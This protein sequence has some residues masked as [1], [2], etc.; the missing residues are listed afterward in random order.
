MKQTPQEII[1]L[2]RH[3]ETRLGEL[4]SERQQVLDHLHDLR[5]QLSLLET[6]PIPVSENSELSPSEKISLFRSL[7]KG[8]EDVKP[9]FPGFFLS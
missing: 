7:F 1:E 8:R 6:A 4:E 3:C 2:I 9:Y 5:K